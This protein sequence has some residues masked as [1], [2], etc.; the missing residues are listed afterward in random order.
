MCSK[1]CA[2]ACPALLQPLLIAC[3]PA[4]QPTRTT[5]SHKTWLLPP[6]GAVGAGDEADPPPRRC[7]ATPALRCLPSWAVAA[8]RR[9]PAAGAGAATRRPGSAGPFE[10]AM[11][12][13]PSAAHCHPLPCCLLPNQL[14]CCYCCCKRQSSSNITYLSVR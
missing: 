3:W 8:H 1:S 9:L 5:H 10:G 7:G 6:A 11:R 13:M 14:Q 12:L 2:V 4:A